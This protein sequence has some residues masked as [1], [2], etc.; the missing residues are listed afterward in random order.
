MSFEDIPEDREISY[1][2]ACGGEITFNFLD[3]KWVCNKCD[4]EAT[5]KLE[6]Q[7]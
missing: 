6:E 4:F 5:K 2:C 7:T 1:P 3:N